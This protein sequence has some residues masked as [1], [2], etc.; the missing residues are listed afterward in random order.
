MTNDTTIDRFESLL[1]EAAV[2]PLDGARRARIDARVSTAI[3][4]AK[5]RPSDGRR[6]RL[7]RPVALIVGVVLAAGAVGAAGAGAEVIRLEW[8]SLPEQQRTPA[9]IRAEIDAAKATTPVPPGYVYPTF[10]VPDNGGVW[11]SYGGQS[12]VEFSAACGWYED[13]TIAFETGDA[14]R[15]GVD[16]GMFDQILA[17]KTIADPFLSDESVRDG[18]RRLNASARAGHPAPIEAWLQQCTP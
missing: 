3:V 10:H 17:W 6:W 2:I 14:K 9:E 4:T 8:G 12:M 11:G 15:M 1:T 18:F 13:W 7:R 5:V 16:Q